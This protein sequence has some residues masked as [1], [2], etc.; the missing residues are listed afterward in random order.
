MPWYFITI[1]RNGQKFYV[2]S[3]KWN[4]YELSATKEK[5]TYLWTSEETARAEPKIQALIQD[6]DEVAYVR[7][8]KG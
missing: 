2:I 1:T 5:N 7:S 6:G 4:Q 3:P 8:W